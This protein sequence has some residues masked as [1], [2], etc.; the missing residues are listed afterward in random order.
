MFDKF[1]L[2]RCLFL[3]YYEDAEFVNFGKKRFLIYDQYRYYKNREIGDVVHWRC[4]GYTRNNC[5]ARATTKL[6]N[7]QQR[8]RINYKDHSHSAESFYFTI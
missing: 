4:V 6:I 3:G 2:I 8:V 1:N 5:R 7:G